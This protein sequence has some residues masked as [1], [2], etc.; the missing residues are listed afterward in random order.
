M[1][2]RGYRGGEGRTKFRHLEYTRNDLIAVLAFIVVT[3]LLFLIR[4][5]L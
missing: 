1:E 5:Y 3:A 2:A 4:I